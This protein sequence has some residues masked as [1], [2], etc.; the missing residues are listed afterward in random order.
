M[1]AATVNTAVAGRTTRIAAYPVRLSAPW[2]G[3]GAW[4]TA[5][6]SPAAATEAAP[7]ASVRASGWPIAAAGPSER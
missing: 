4:I 7:A 5:V 3:P 6:I 1:A 2:P